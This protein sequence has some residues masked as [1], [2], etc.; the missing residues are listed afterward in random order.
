M[1]HSLTSVPWHVVQSLTSVPW[2][3][4]QSLTQ[5]C[6]LPPSCPRYVPPDAPCP[7]PPSLPQVRGT[8]NAGLQ[9]A[10]R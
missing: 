10:V 5:V 9:Q 7:L 2:N 4:L 8:K 3:V 6:A 1:V